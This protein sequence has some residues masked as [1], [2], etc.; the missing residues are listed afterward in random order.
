MSVPDFM[1][2]KLNS[3]PQEMAG[4]TK[5]IRINYLGAIEI[6]YLVPIH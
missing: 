4:L 3:K 6:E 1:V 5:V 2:D